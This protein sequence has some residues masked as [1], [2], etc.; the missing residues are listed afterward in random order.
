MPP[1]VPRIRAVTFDVGGTLLDP[2]PSVGHI[3]SDVAAR[4]GYKGISAALLN[5]RFA[6]AWRTLKNFRH[7]RSQWAGL[8]DATF[9]GLT[10]PPPSHSF[11]PKLYNRFA[12]R[13]A[14]HL[15]EDVLPALQALAAHGLKLG[16]ISNWDDRLRPLLR[17]FKLH[18]HCDVIIVS[19]EVGAAKPARAIF[20]RAA[21][22]LRLV[23]ETIL[24]VGDSLEMDVQGAR[25]AGLQSL[26]LRRK[27]KRRFPC[28]IQSLDQLAGFIYSRGPYP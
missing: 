10:E 28:E 22:E 17:A 18:E 14:W 13:D 15:Y 11:F 6:A 5:R 16:I 19:C 21:A 7:T 8:V 20:R 24:H 23:P 3:Y 4:H 1:S 26:L 9:R 12:E 2:Y 25:A 27:A